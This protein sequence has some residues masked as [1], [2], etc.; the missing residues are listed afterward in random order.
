[1]KSNRKAATDYYVDFLTGIFGDVKTAEW[2][3]ENFL[4]RLSDEQFDAQMKRQL[5]GEDFISLIVPNLDSKVRI[6]VE[7]NMAQAKKMGI[8]FF[9]HLRITDQVSGVTFITPKKYLVCLLPIR[10]QAQTLEKKISIPDDNRH[11]DESTGQAT[12][13]SKGSSVSFPE[14]QVLYA[15][16]FDKAIVEMI[17]FR[18][19]DTKAFQ[20]MNKVVN[21][22]GHVSLNQ[23]S[24]MGT[25]VKATTSLRT[26]FRAMHLEPTL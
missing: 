10:R 7:R 18:G 5:S 6:S 2:H 15:Q 1:M 25:E 3:R 13:V 4:D 23:L 17:K 9:Q 11:I 26:Y 16:G 24:R 21:D 20:A 19:G 12:G 8:E 14:L 22:T